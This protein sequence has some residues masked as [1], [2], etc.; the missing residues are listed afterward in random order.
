MIFQ[1]RTYSVLIV[2][3]SSKFQQMMQAFLPMT[4]Y[5][6]VNSAGSVS[7]ARRS[8]IEVEYDIVLIHTPLKDEFGSEL[9]IDICKS[10]NSGVLMFVKSEMYDDIYA[11]VMDKGV[12]VLSTP[13][14]APMV[15]QTLRIM[16]SARERLR[17]ME[18]RQASIEDKITEMRLMNRA[19]WMLIEREH[20][21][22]DEAHR[23]IEKQA[24]DGRISGRSAAERIIA[25]Y[26]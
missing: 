9:A 6:P 12:M 22:E 3:A 16:C 4:D 14:P 15:A 8:L 1:E 19:K 10:S 7:A 21:T 26:S 25:R 5:Y 2:S 18:V 13:A 17:L 11:K 23:Y 20:M 24:M